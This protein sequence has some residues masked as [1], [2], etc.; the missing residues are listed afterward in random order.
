MTRLDATNVT[1]RQ[2]HQC[3]GCR[4][5]IPAGSPMRVVVEKDRGFFSRGYWCSVCVNVLT[6]VQDDDVYA[7]G[8]I[9]DSNPE[10]WE[11]ERDRQ[12]AAANAILGE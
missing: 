11:A 9:I 2:A 4:R 12:A 5:V 7:C 8:D 10:A 1:T 3:W 6:D